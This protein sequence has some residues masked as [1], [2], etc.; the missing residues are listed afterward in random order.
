SPEPLQGTADVLEAHRIDVA[1][2]ETYLR[3][4]IPG[5]AG[6][7]TLCQFRGGQ[8]NP[9]YYLGTPDRDYVL[10]RK[11]PGKLLPSAHA[12]DREYRVIT[13]LARPA[14]PVP[15]PY[16]LGE[17]PGVIGTIFYVMECVSGRVLADPQ[18]PGCTPAERGA[19]YEAMS[20]VLMRLH[21]VDWQTV[22]LAD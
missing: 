22:G 12:V 20:D 6:P 13:A 10:R 21:R 9:T 18:L 14:G 1:A 8:S 19:I 16:L 7:L 2:L 3:A 4:Q 15:R 5:F 17:D 11:P